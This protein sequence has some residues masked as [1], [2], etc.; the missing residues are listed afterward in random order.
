M[1]FQDIIGQQALK[2]HLQTAIRTGKTSHAYIIGGEK[3]SGKKMLAEAFAA[4]LLCE[5]H[6]EDACGTCHSC[7]QAVNHNQPDIIY[8]SHENPNQISVDDVRQQIN[9]DIVIR[10]YSSSHKVYIVD[11]AEK[12]NIAAQN[13]LL[14]TIEEPPEYAVI[15]LLTT[16]I[17]AFLPTI[18]SR[19]ITLEMKPVPDELVK[20]YLM[21]TQGIPDYQADMSV[22]FAQGNLGKAVLLCRSEEFEEMRTDV[23]TIGRTILDKRDYEILNIVQL[24]NERCQSKEE[25]KKTIDRSMVNEYLDLFRIWYRDVLLYK[26]AGEGARLIFKDEV[27]HIKRQAERRSYA[28]LNH[29]F[30]ALEDTRLKLNANVSFELTMELLFK[31]MKES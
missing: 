17:D 5:E 22:N 4:T 16:N 10:P 6:T 24:I 13:A 23:V 29:I 20:K 15:L 14:K 25:K 7:K 1:R 18:L 3:G 8:V 2:N 27:N 19:C 30:E 12:M 31:A 28:G 21:Q 11:E 26:S 9:N